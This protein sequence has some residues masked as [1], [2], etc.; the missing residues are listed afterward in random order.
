[1]GL[2]LLVPLYP[3]ILLFSPVIS[4]VYGVVMSSLDFSTLLSMI[5]G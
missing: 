5:F 3:F 1:M 4:T 2:L